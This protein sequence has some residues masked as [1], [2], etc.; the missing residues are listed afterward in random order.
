[1]QRR[2]VI[3]ISAMCVLLVLLCTKAA[4][5]PPQSEVRPKAH[6]AP[7]MRTAEPA[8]STF[9]A[10][11]GPGLYLRDET[12][13]CVD[14]DGSLVTAA[15]DYT[16]DGTRFWCTGAGDGLRILS[17]TARMADGSRYLISDGEIVQSSGLTEYDGSLYYLNPDFTLLCD[18]SWNTLCFGADGRY[19]SGDTDIDAFVDAIIASETSAS[20]TQEEKLRAC[21]EYVFYHTDYQSDN[22]HVTRGAA[23]SSWTQDAMHRLMERG[24][25]NCYCYAAEMYYLARRLGYY[26]ARAISGSV[27][28]DNDHGWLEIPV[29]GVPTV[30]DPELESKNYSAPGHLFLTPY[31]E[32]PW[33]Y[34][35]D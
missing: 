24:K 8:A 7:T 30:V 35:L 17:H 32:T 20:M 25:G 5:Q 29:D 1:M 22:H 3:V 11:A 18:D 34:Y 28:L 27:M 10:A 12:F 19:T 23:M 15:G 4:W 26:N 16:V 33:H 13:Y 6:A 2:T 14:S 21:Y 31:D 9:S